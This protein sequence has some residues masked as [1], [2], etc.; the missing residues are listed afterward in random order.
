MGV[1]VQK[2]VQ[3]NKKVCL[4][5]SVSQEPYIIWVSFMVHICKMII[6]SDTFHI[7]SKFWFCG[8][9]GQ[10]TVQNDI[11]LCLSRSISQEPYIIRLSFMVQMCKIIIS[12]GDSFNFENLIFWVVRG[13]KGK[14]KKKAQ[15]Y[16][17]F[18]LSQS[19]S[20]ELYIISLGFLVHMKSNF[21]LF[22]PAR[23]WKSLKEC[24]C[25]QNVW[26]LAHNHIKA[27]TVGLYSIFL[28]NN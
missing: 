23:Y 3:N 12:P 14:K 24:K 28:M 13:L 19:V 18:C 5:H 15:N 6:Y 27:K 11:K 7:F 16:K 20:R 21:Y 2:T 26:N 17:H 1:K 9:I 4:L 22:L 10:T 25:L 8:S